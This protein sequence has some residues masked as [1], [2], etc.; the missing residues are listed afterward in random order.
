MEASGMASHVFVLGLPKCGTTSLHHAL[1]SAGY[2]S[3]HWALGKGGYKLVNRGSGAE[4]R[5]VGKLMQRAL[6][7]GLE[8]L[9]FL[10]QGTNAVAQMD[11]LYW[12]RAGH[13][14]GYF[15][16]NVSNYVAKVDGGLSNVEIHSQHQAS[17]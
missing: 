8:P 7:A 10:P 2:V 11:Y 15:S 13:V 14:L 3:V 1:E 4:H 16:A 9:H 5:L 6:A 17:G 12:D